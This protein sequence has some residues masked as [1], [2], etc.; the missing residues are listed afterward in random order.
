MT[1]A[2]SSPHTLQ[3]G[4]TVTV[5]GVAVAGYN[6]TYTVTA[7]PSS[8]SFQYTSRTT[9]LP[10]S[11]GGT[12][13]PAIPGASSSGTT[14]TIHTSTPHGRSVGDVVVIS[15]VCGRRLQRHVHDHSRPEPD[16]RSSTRSRASSANA[17]GGSST[18]YSPFK[19]RIGGNDSVLIGGTGL[20]YTAAN[21]TTAINGIAGFAGTVTVTSATAPGFTIA[22]AGASA[23][24][25]VPNIELVELNCGAASPPSRR[26]TT[27]ARSTRSGSTTTGTCPRRS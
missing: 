4:E 24:M 5:S 19:V 17:G 14:A 8:R 18:Y 1:I 22:Y 3:V 7:V 16:G 11:G 21:L 27:A 26:R 9:G 2:T 12:A 23:G 25:D 20:P 13:T 10:V 15:G 6:G